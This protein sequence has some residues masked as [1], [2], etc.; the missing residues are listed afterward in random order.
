LKAAE[1][2]CEEIDIF[3]KKIGMWLGFKKFGVDRQTLR[4]IANRSHDLPDYKAN[5]VIADIDEIYR[6]L[7]VGLERT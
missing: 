3:L 2:C 6:Q 5:P 4:E 1:L 7:Q